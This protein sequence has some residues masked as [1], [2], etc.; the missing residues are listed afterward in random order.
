MSAQPQAAA[1]GSPRV[2]TISSLNRELA[3]Y[4][5]RLGAVWVSG[6]LSELR[7]SDRWGLVFMTLKDPE[8]GSLLLATMQ[9]ARFDAL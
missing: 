9:R 1:A 6:E 4:I 7:R 5:R 2:W 3:G 8:D